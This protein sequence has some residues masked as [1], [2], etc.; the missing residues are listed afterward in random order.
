MDLSLGSINVKGNVLALVD[1]RRGHRKSSYGD[2]RRESEDEGS[3]DIGAHCKSF[4]E[5]SL[6]DGGFGSC[7]KDFAECERF[8]D[9]K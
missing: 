8:Y 9:L 5:I 7:L 1:S 2:C 4:E 6:G 3:E